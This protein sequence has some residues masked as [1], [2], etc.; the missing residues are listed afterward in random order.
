MAK[1]Q[2]RS[3]P[4]RIA[5]LIDWVMKLFPVRVFTYYATAQGPLLATGLAFQA[6]FAT[7]AAVWVGFCV[8]GLVVSGNDQLQQS[9]IDLLATAV[10]GLIQTSTSA[11]AIDPTVLLNAG[12][13]TWTGAIALIGV[14]IT[15][16][17][18]LGSAR[19]AVRI[20]FNAP[21][22]KTNFVLVKLKDL[23]VALC[24]GLLFLISAALSVVGSSATGAM[25]TFFGVSPTSVAGQIVG[26]TVSL[27]I[28]F[29]LNAVILGALFRVLS[30][31]KIPFS[32]LRGGILIG[33]AGIGVLQLVAGAL[34]GVSKNNPLLASFAV[35][36]G[37]LIY[38]NFVCQAILI[39][40]SW[41]AVAAS[42]KGISIGPVA[43]N[44]ELG[45][46]AEVSAAQ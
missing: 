16:I 38:F 25:L 14:F 13:Y 36:L 6:L 42:D 1:T 32:R 19:V 18:W 31:V 34:L 33:A 9:L 15:A 35:I 17:G 26:R 23:I 43:I 2:E 41:V 11:G 20:I 37:L 44:R 46:Q 24:F 7:F 28:M 8:I 29:A 22:S 45:D 40:A 10:P 30:G 39:S 5:R 3:K 12:V 4:G 27:V 21:P